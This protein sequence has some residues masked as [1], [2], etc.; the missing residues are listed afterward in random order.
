VNRY[1]LSAVLLLTLPASAAISEI[2]SKSKWNNTL[3]ACA[4]PSMTVGSGHLIAVWTSWHTTGANNITASVGDSLSN[5]SYVSAVGP[6]LQPAS[7]TAGQIFY[8]RSLQTG[9]VDIVTVTFSSTPTSSNCVAV[10]YSGLDPNYPLDSV[11]S[12]YSYSAGTYMD[13]GTAAPANANL[14]VFGGWPSRSLPRH[15]V[16]HP[17]EFHG[18]A[19]SNSPWHVHRGMFIGRS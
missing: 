6:T 8:I 16:P 18:W 11:S 15:G 9:G 13:S 4:V 17:W 14:A 7:N 10:E 2:Q 5:Q 19:S 3:A 1:L 12:G